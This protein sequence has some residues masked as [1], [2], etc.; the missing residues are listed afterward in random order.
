MS[1]SYKGLKAE[2][3]LFHAKACGGGVLWFRN[4]DTNNPQRVWDA[5]TNPSWLYWYLGHLADCGGDPS[6]A[7]TRLLRVMCLML[8]FTKPFW[9]S[10]APER[11]IEVVENSLLPGGTRKNFPWLFWSDFRSTANTY[12]AF[13]RLKNAY[14]GPGDDVTDLASEA[15]DFGVELHRLFVEGNP[16]YWNEYPGYHLTARQ[17]VDMIRAAVPKVP[18]E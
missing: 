17:H 13:S 9:A 6:W 2:E 18:L 15:N 5:C 11:A 3:I 10:E 8:R 16:E 4:L 14:R 12:E 1:R 7:R